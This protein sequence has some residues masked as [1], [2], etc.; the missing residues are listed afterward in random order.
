M[1]SVDL[2]TG[3]A[4]NGVTAIAPGRRPMPPDYDA[5]H[6]WF[7]EVRD[8]LASIAAP[9]KL[10]ARQNLDPCWFRS[11]LRFVNL[12]DVVRGDVGMRFR[13]RL[14]G[15]SQ[16]D[17]ARRE[18]TGLFVED[19]VLPAYVERITTNMR[20]VVGT[21]APIYDRF[22]MPHLDREFIDSERV[23][24]PLASDGENVDMILV[25]CN[26]PGAAIGLQSHDVPARD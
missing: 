24:F 13:F 19:A 23:Y 21:K 25:A 26:Y 16:T 6:P 12:V 3:D 11:T 15:T 10:A 9:G 5:L 2:Q 17:L 18:I 7:R 20:T 4:A 1:H 8:Y 14:V 22:P